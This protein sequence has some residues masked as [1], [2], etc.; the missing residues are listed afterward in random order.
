MLDS[1]Y[2][3][4]SPPLGHAAKIILDLASVVPRPPSP[5]RLHVI[6]DCDKPACYVFIA[7]PDNS[8]GPPRTR[9]E[10]GGTRSFPPG[11]HRFL[12]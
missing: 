9:T 5:S 2:L 7:V 4:M 8:A 6:C 1:F 11:G 10:P 3:I 12:N